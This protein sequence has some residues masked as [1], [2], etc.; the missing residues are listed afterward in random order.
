MRIPIALLLFAHGIAHV[1][2]F[3]AAFRLGKAPIPYKTTI[4]AGHVDV[5]D[6]GVRAL[7]VLWLAAAVAFAAAAVAALARAPWWPSAALG[8][9]I[10]SLGMCM[11]GWPDARI[12]LAVN[13]AL[14]ALMIVGA[15][16]GW[17]QLAAR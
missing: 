6:G 15:R 13:A 12:G 1:V 11:V 9:A 3:L 5:G 2:G 10:G 8:L 16:A 17:F 7:G 4:F 14:I